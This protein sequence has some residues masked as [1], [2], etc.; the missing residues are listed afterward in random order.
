MQ[1]SWCDALMVF[2]DAKTVIIDEKEVKSIV[3]QD[4]GVLYEKENLINEPLVVHFVG[5][6]FS[7]I[8]TDPFTGRN[9]TIDWGDGTI[10]NYTP[11]DAFEH[12]YEDNTEHIIRISNIT[13]VKQQAFYDTNLTKVFVPSNII[14]LGSGAFSNCQSLEQIILSEGLK[15][16]GFSCFAVC[17]N[18]D[19]LMDI[20]IP[21]SVT[22]M[23]MSC[24]L[25]VYITKMNFLW[26]T[27]ESIIPY[28]S[29]VYRY[30][31]P[32][33]TFYIPEG[34]TQLYVDKGY[35]LE[36]LVEGAT[37][38]TLTSDKNIVGVG[39]TAVITGTLNYPSQDKIV[40]FNTKTPE[41]VTMT[42]GNN[43]YSIGENGF[44]ITD[45]SNAFF[46]TSNIDNG[47]YLYVSYYG[48]S[49][50]EKALSVFVRTEDGAH[51]PP[52]VNKLRYPIKLHIDEN[53]I[54]TY[55][56][57]DYE[58]QEVIC[59][60]KNLS[61]YRYLDEYTK[62]EGFT[63]WQLSGENSLT[64]TKNT[65]LSA[66]TN[67]NGQATMAYEG[68][69]AGYITITGTYLDKN[70]SDDITIYDGE[71]TTPIEEVYLISLQTNKTV[72]SAKNNDSC[73]LNATVLDDN[74]N[75]VE[76]QE[77]TFKNGTTILDTILTD[78]NGE[79]AYEYISRGL[80]DISIKAEINS[81]SSNTITIEDCFETISSPNRT[82]FDTSWHPKPLEITGKVATNG[83]WGG[84]RIYGGDGQNI[85]IHYV[86]LSQN[87]SNSG[88]SEQIRYNLTTT[89]YV[90]FKIVID[91]NKISLWMN[92]S[93]YSEKTLT[94]SPYVYMSGGSSANPV[95]L[96]NVK[97]K[98]LL[99]GNSLSLTSDKSALSYIDNDFCTLT[100]TLT[101][102]D[103]ANKPV[104]FKN[105]NIILDTINTD[106]NGIATYTYNSEGAGDVI[107]TVEYINLQE[108]YEIQDCL[109]YDTASSDKTSSYGSII[110]Y[111]GG[112]GQW[113]YNATNGYYGTL[114]G[115]NEVMVDLTELT[116]EDDFIIEFD[117][118]LN[119]NDGT[120]YG[121]AGI[122]AYEDN[123]NYS[124]LSCHSRKI[125]QRVSVNGSATENETDVFSVSRGD[126]LHFKFTITNNQIIEEVTKG[127]TSIGTKTISYTPT[128][129]TKYGLALVWKNS[130]T[131]NTFLKNIKIKPL[132]FNGSMS[133]FVSKDIL[134]YADNDSCTLT[135][136]LTGDN[137][138]NRPV[139]FK[140]GS[141][142]LD[143]VNTD[144]N[145]VATYTYNSQGVG[146][147]T[148]TAEYMNLQETYEFE[149][150]LWTYLSEKTVTRSSSST[151]TEEVM[152]GT[153]LTLPNKFEF[154]FDLK[155][156]LTGYRTYLTPVQYKTSDD[157]NYALFVQQTST[158]YNVGY[159][160]TSTNALK[161][162][163]NID[164]TSYQKW[165][166]V[167]DGNTFTYYLNDVQVA[168][169]SN[170]TWFDNYSP[171]TI[172]FNC[173]TTGNVSMKNIK[174]KP[175]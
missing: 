174:I 4:G 126:L 15:S 44:D 169:T 80:G 35:P 168:T 88:E 142:I 50:G 81:L 156:T 26:D 114:S 2:T 69:G 136:T 98:S 127:T 30:P 97:I 112:S 128:N 51:F 72:L 16:I 23:G 117:A 170:P 115:S 135:A 37:S 163:T 46:L 145:G 143:T 119:A 14:S 124:R 66:L 3:L 153:S 71:T 166:I 61:N 52:L 92:D 27:S 77:V 94:T 125:A 152:S 6:N 24:F 121:I 74:N 165:K 95:S 154:T 47:Y 109:R 5:T 42:P 62:E 149:D 139:V 8:T 132:P 86:F 43:Y 120:M 108:T 167:R 158:F 155:S 107:F 10:T 19:N 75:P 54:I 110:S 17:G 106:S 76:N 22:S 48:A 85:N 83:P 21:S 36:K 63:Q 45:F 68:F 144:S 90:P 102:D 103:V 104:V 33:L 34:T 82:G 99:G 129:N 13:E 56:Y 18:E 84:T 31:H 172:V 133:I 11:G 59:L 141:T 53:N 162:N 32:D 57:K 122:C 116:G 73:I 39:E 67:S 58:E 118:L 113:N 123:N 25:A 41:S 55:R 96:S 65:G 79:A 101:G 64:V 40:V 173:W 78:E 140:N 70:V 49:N 171:H 7:S 157:P 12:T 150:C 28:N 175:L 131:S 89:A 38:I 138:A 91:E 111:R 146:D 148:I 87:S 137:V 164:G 29:D 93:L 100:A 20:T 161:S 1:H 151:I 134:S 147:V 9:I 160:T 159:R 130:W 105:G 60:V